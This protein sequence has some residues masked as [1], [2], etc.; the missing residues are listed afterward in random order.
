MRTSDIPEVLSLP[1]FCGMRDD[2][3]AALMRAA[4]V[5]TFPPHVEIVSEGDA[6]DFLHIVVDGSVEL[7]ASWGGR[8]TSMAIV[9]PVNTFILAATIR[10]APYLMSARTV[11]K[12]RMV[13]VPSSDVR[14]AFDTDNAFARAVV[15]E[16][17][18]AYRTVVKGTKNLKLRT[19]IERLANH[20]LRMREISGG[21][22]EF[23]LDMEKRRLA[24]LLGMTPENLSRAI[25]ALQPYGVEVDNSRVRI[26]N[27]D[28]LVK[29]ARPTPLIDDPD[30]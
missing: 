20:L 30:R 9:Q 15:A 10:D 1:L 16:L 2:S 17:A 22:P 19:S 5:Q 27:P 25:R 21:G 3:F 7:F 6:C 4:Y 12:T 29:L 8:E 14:A 26:E 18:Q 28:E 11:E 24:S 13:L 23:V